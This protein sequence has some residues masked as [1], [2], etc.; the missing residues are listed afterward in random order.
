MN[1]K[2]QKQ[3]TE[4]MQEQTNKEVANIPVQV[5]EIVQ[6]EVAPTEPEKEVVPEVQ[7]S[8][9]DSE[10]I[11]EVSSEVGQNDK[12]VRGEF[13]QDS[14]DDEQASEEGS[15]DEGTKEIQ[16]EENN[17]E[18]VETKEEESQPEEEEELSVDIE[19]L[20][21]ELNELKAE[22]EEEAR[23]KELVDVAQKVE[24]EYDRVVNGV[25]E[26]LR[27]TLEQYQIPTDK[28]IKEL[29]TE[30][31]AKAKIA[32]DLIAQAKQVLD[33]NT[34]QLTNTYRAKEQDVIFTKAE[35]LFNKYEMTNEQ[36]QVA[37]DTFI[38]ILQAS[39][40]QDLN[41]DLAAKVELSVAQARFK[42]PTMIE[43]APEVQVAAKEVP[44]VQPEV[45]PEAEKAVEVES[46]EETK[47]EAKEDV[48]IERGVAK[49]APKKVDLNGYKEGIV[50]DSTAGA[51]KAV[52]TSNV[53]HKL[54][55]LPAKE[56]QQFL[57]ENFA[58]VNKAMKETVI[59][60]KGF[61]V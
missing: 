30:D 39:G 42:I 51:N 29:E 4:K 5:G 58:L 19:Q 36:A 24:M 55:T 9:K 17:E 57:K 27:E 38:S 28:T 41:E 13:G 43:K 61:T 26:A 56:R 11:V 16:Q 1:E 32:R 44:N 3:E 50:G 53:L 33:Y 18:A 22:K 6:H 54:A 2:T 46:E 40:L 20:Q 37:A 60:S 7:E 23:V 12:D 48:A 31:P 45:A 15:E 35:R 25:N 8:A 59:K 14:A 21:K 47:E 52:D 49:E 10:Q 34:Q